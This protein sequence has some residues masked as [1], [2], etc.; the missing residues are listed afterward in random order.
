[1]LCHALEDLYINKLS[2]GLQQDPQRSCCH[3]SGQVTLVAY[4]TVD[5]GYQ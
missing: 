1:M 4:L 3:G 2:H 5:L